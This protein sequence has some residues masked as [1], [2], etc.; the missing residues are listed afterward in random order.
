MPLGLE[1]PDY[2]D[3][4]GIKVAVQGMLC[5]T[6]Q[7]TYKT[8]PPA[9]ASVQSRIKGLFD[10]KKINKNTPEAMA[11]FDA[12]NQALE[13]GTMKADGSQSKQQKPMNP[14]VLEEFVKKPESLDLLKEKMQKKVVATAIPAATPLEFPKLDW[15]RVE[16]LKSDPVYGQLFTKHQIDLLDSEGSFPA[17][18]FDLPIS[19]HSYHRGVG[20]A[21]IREGLNAISTG[22]DGVAKDYKGA[23]MP[24]AAPA[25]W[26]PLV[27]FQ[28]KNPAMYAKFED[29]MLRQFVDWLKSIASFLEN[30]GGS[31]D[32]KSAI[33]ALVHRLFLH[34]NEQGTNHCEDPKIM[35]SHFFKKFLDV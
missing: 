14:E 29:L 7:G 31:V 27:D 25:G 24:K 1:V 6:F 2:T 3:L 18:K 11:A 9:V 34:H 22:T 12:L 21:A 15:A 23:D 19:T 4:Q 28:A 35:H 20:P 8:D 13:L 30:I 33:H 32:S 16:T 5:T 17:A 26:T 10:I